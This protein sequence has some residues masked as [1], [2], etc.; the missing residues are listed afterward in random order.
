MRRS[1][2]L[3]L[4]AYLVP[5]FILGYVWHLRLFTN[6]YHELGIYRPDVIIPLGFLSMLVQGVIFAAAYPRVVDQPWRLASGMRFAALAAMLSWSF[7]TLAVAA[8]HPMTSVGGFMLI[9][10]MF[11]IVQ[12]ALVAPLLAWSA[13]TGSVALARPDQ[14]A[15]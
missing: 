10:T 3:A 7:T 4:L 8:K 5:T 9:E 2:T 14:R 12:F 15:A 1:F 13:R 6:Y 11:T